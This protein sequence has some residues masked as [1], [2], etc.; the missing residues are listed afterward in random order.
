MYMM[1]MMYMFELQSRVRARATLQPS[2]LNIRF[3]PNTSV[4]P[5]YLVCFPP[6]SGPI[7]CYVPS[8]HFSTSSHLCIDIADIASLFR[9][10]NVDR[11]G[12]IQANRCHLLSRSKESKD[13]AILPM[14]KHSSFTCFTCFTTISVQSSTQLI[15]GGIL[16]NI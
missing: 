11:G 5:L 4:S 8:S 3:A 15:H 16:F 14:A 12:Q 10:Y 7:S 6:V 1:Y 9:R 2:R 13:K